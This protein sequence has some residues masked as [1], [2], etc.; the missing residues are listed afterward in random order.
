MG[1]S[2][3]GVAC[4]KI[5]AGSS[6]SHVALIVRIT[7]IGGTCTLN[8]MLHLVDLAGSEGVKTRPCS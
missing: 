8:G 4:T 6:H 2:N 5:D 7:C 1:T 3:R